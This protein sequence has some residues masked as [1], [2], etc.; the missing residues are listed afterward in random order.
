MKPDNP[1]TI[2]ANLERDA[3]VSVVGGF[4]KPF[5]I[6]RLAEAEHGSLDAQKLARVRRLLLDTK[7]RNQP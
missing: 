6:V 7:G 5:Y 2:R 4:A 3:G 1:K